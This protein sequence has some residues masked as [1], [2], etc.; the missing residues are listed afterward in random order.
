METISDQE[1][2]FY[3]KWEKELQ[4]LSFH[5]KEDYTKFS[6]KLDDQENKISS[7]TASYNEHL[8]KMRAN[9][10]VSTKVEISIIDLE[11]TMN[12]ILN[13]FRSVTVR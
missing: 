3:T 9:K 7:F 10:K 2:K 12:M 8:D 6:L 13:E 4:T 11:A 1:A 5:I